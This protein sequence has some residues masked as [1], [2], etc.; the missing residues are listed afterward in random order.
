MADYSQVHPDLK[1]LDQFCVRV[2]KQ[3]YI[4]S[5]E[6]NGLSVGGFS[7]AG[8]SSR[9]ADWLSFNEAIQALQDK[10]EAVFFNGE[11][12][13]L[14]GIGFIVARSGRGGPQVLGGDLDCCRDPETGL[15]SQWATA[16]L[17][18]A[19]PFYTEV[20]LSKCGIR[21]FS[22]GRLPECRDNVFGNGPQ[23]DMP[24]ETRERILEAKPKAREK[25]AK[26]EPAFNG[27]ELYETGRH[28]TLTGEKLDEFCFEKEDVTA[29]L[30]QALAPF[31]E[32]K[33]AKKAQKKS[34]GGNRL[35]SLDIQDVIDTNGF[36]EDGGQLFGPHPTKG[37][38]TGKNLV[39]NPGKNVYCWM[40]NSINAGGDPWVWLACEC[41]AVPWEQAGSGVL[42]DPKVRRQTL[43][44]AIKRGFVSTDEVGL[45]P[46]LDFIIGD[47]CKEEVV[48]EGK[49]NE[50]IKYKFSPDKAAD[51]ITKRFDVVTAE[52]DEI[53]IYKNGIYSIEGWKHVSDLVK[54]IA[55][56][57]FPT[58]EKKELEFAVAS[59]TRGKA[60]DFNKNPYILCCKNRT[61][62][63]SIGEVMEHSPKHLLTDQIDVDYDPNA[64]CPLFLQYLE[65]VAPNPTD[66]LMLIDWYAIHAI[67]EM[68]PYVLF[69]NG[70]GR[71][72]KGIYER[73]L[74]RFFG[75]SAFSSMQLEE[76]NVKNNRFAG[77]DLAGKRGQIVSEAGG[78][79]AKGK[80][81]IPTAF[82]KNATGDGIIDSDQKNKGRIKFK[83]FYKAT[84]DSNDMP[85]IEDSSKGWI[86]RFCKAD[87]PFSY[88]D[89]PDPNNPLERKKDP[90]LFDKLTTA[91]ELSGILNL[92][93]SRT[94]EIIKTGAITK[95][96][97]SE[98]FAEYQKQSNSVTTFLES[99]C[100]YK[101]VISEKEDVPLDTVYNAYVEWC[102]LT[103][104]D[105]VNDQR[106][107]AAVKNLCNGIK[108][109]RIRGSDGNRFR[110]YH[111]FTFDVKAYQ[112]QMSQP[113]PTL[114]QQNKKQSQVSQDIARKWDNIKETF[115]R[116]KILH[117]S[118]ENEKPPLFSALGPAIDCQNTAGTDNGQ[119]GTELDH[120]GPDSDSTSNR[121]EESAPA[122]GSFVES[123]DSQDLP[124]LGNIDRPTPSP[125]LVI[126]R[127]LQDK[128]TDIDGKQ[129]KFSKE[130][131]AS[132][133]AERVAEWVKLGVVEVVRA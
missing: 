125:A 76:L 66:R 60:A 63:L 126:V 119:V 18:L 36:L 2:Q 109:E 59:K 86:E 130:D 120:I 128:E 129:R 112:S 4:A 61:I 90:H 62:D 69:L 87:M 53:W 41:G 40:H 22:W 11:Y 26:G 32:A 95:R 133:P 16:F 33:P 104:S 98:M 44:H 82:L 102:K 47:L 106:F 118:S 97:G 45:K 70:L 68:F 39:V 64:K 8:W 116:E 93:L 72:G 83:P 127:F 74:K 56:D 5:A 29:A 85:R 103:V 7:S 79:Q 49:P 91:P 55:A 92:I 100:G 96:P 111:G 113:V 21:F 17:Q 84:V 20:S 132:I 73:V 19:R 15:V 50:Y 77:A 75:E 122:P 46:K 67:R 107:G 101:P 3:P 94:Q 28:L 9:R 110:I 57:Y 43:D 121:E 42:S 52:D 88:V 114:S 81:A 71:N 31:L 12:V 23:D 117:I 10:N 80:R 34:S 58:K 38:A 37:S 65:D 124:T 25:L 35:P 123:S 78:S 24:A 105:I 51:T 99:F 48:N 1:E 54:N 115:G 13:P 89:E 131:V 14:E 27:V 108:S 30:S 6:V